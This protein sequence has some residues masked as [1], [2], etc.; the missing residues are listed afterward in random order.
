VGEG[1]RNKWGV[2]MMTV[3]CMSFAQCVIVRISVVSD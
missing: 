2:T 1:E 3:L